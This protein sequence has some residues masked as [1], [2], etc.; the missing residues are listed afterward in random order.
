MAVEQRRRCGYR[1]LGGLYLV[2]GPGGMPCD[3][4]PLELTV[5]PTCSQGI[6]QSRGWTWVDVAALV[7]GTHRGCGDEWECPFCFRP[8]DMGMAGLLWVGG[9]FYPSVKSFEDEARAM[10]ISRR[11]AAVP[12]GFAAGK[13]WVLLAHPKTIARR[14][15]CVRD[16]YESMSLISPPDPKCE[17]CEGTGMVFTT[18]IFK[19]WQPLRIEKILEESKR[20]TEEHL[21][22]EKRNITPVFVPD[23]DADHQGN[24]FDFDEVEEAEH[25]AG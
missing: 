8:G 10:G 25:A 17:H 13:T 2:S 1:K 6:K 7:D 3:R 9:K 24:V 18:G 12:R 19:V 21:D 22:L 23:N 20:G 14:C 11:I 5:C 16:G 4:L 15:G